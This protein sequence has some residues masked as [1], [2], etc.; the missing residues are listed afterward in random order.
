MEQNNIQENKTFD[1]R[2]KKATHILGKDRYNL[3]AIETL[4]ELSAELLNDLGED[5][6]KFQSQD[7]QNIIRLISRELNYAMAYLGLNSKNQ[8]DKYN[9]TEPYANNC[10]STMT[11]L[12]NQSMTM[13]YPQLVHRLALTLHDYL[14][15][16]SE[17]VK[18]KKIEVG[19]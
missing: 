6:D 12:L 16:Y 18:T 1:I 8:N 7:F 13:E 4:F 2:L 14:S 5:H 3:V 9:F 11:N 19:K 17:D 10:H 15:P